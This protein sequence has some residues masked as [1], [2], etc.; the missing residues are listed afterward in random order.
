MI[1]S[2]FEIEPAL[3]QRLRDTLPEFV[4]VDS[5]GVLAGVQNL[6]PLC[7]AALVLPL[8]FAGPVGTPPPNVF[9]AERQRWQVTVC[10][11]HAPPASTVVTGGEY[12]LRV[13]RALEHW[14]PQPGWGR[15]KHVGL[16]D[17]WF[18]LGHVEFSLVF[19]VRPLPLDTGTP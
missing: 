16:D 18:D 3:I 14:S 5:V 19:E 9:L 11:A 2:L 10:V 1:A 12:V 7:P 4:T 17:P 15:L 6:E 13:L 8:G